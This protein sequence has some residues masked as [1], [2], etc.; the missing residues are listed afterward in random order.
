MK[1]RNWS[2][3]ALALASLIVVP[4]ML[5]DGPQ[6]VEI[7]S[8]HFSVVTD[9]GEKR[10]REVAMRFEQMR[11]V[12]GALMAKAKVDNPIPLQIVAFRNTKEFRQFAPLWQGKA[13]QLS[14]LFQPG[15]D[16]SFILLDMSV[17][18]PWNVVFHEYAHQLMNGM[19]VEETEPWFQE[20]FAEF[21]ASIEVD[22][23]EAKVGKVPDYTY[24]ILG[25]T[26]WIKVSDLLAVRHQ[27]ATYNESGDRRTAF[28]A[29]SAL[30]V[31]YFYDN[32]MIP[33]L[34]VYF[35]LR[36][37]KNASVDDAVQQ[38]FGMSSAQFDKVIHDY[39]RSGHYKYYALATPPDIAKGGY[40]SAA[41]SSAQASAI[42]ADVHLHSPDYRDNAI[43]EF[44]A[45]LKEDPNNA[46][47]WRGLGYAYLEKQ[48][49]TEAA[50]HFRRAA[51]LDPKDARVH[52]YTAML[53]QKEGFFT[54]RS[55]LPEMIHELET[56]VSLD[57]NLADAYSLLGFAQGANGDVE[58]GLKTMQKAIALNPHNEWYRYNLAVMFM[59]DRKPAPAIA[60]FEMLTKSQDQR[61]ALG[62]TQSLALA[63]RMQEA[64][65]ANRP[66]QVRVQ[67]DDDAAGD[68]PQN[69]NTTAGQ[70]PPPLSGRV[71][72]LKGTLTSVDCST[73]PSA[74][75]SVTS[76]SKTWKLKAEDTHRVVVLGADAFSCSW[77]KQKVALNY[78]Q[79]GPSEGRIVSVEIQ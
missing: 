77:N 26:G 17:E 2:G 62:A 71:Q 40:D 67:S 35:D 70:G 79:T 53:M 8:P 30:L 51:Q 9:A 3:W 33:K 32:Q 22:N 48:Q 10:G 57:P 4:S 69:S 24:Q 13:T 74:V 72:F 58:T 20:G 7:R 75:L 60:I 36:A 23:K 18:N 6:W 45:V 59:N 64:L 49:F 5:A 65:A 55:K 27:S 68:P 78:V 73:P 15:T 28:Y 44:Q 56:A 61:M 31:H 66:I 11:G 47:A 19:V 46:T 25:Q 12:F 42:L 39:V 29:E 16:R 41:V 37:N 34:A 1:A 14:G 38:A 52:F 76:G 63:R 21:F 43:L 50:E 54:D